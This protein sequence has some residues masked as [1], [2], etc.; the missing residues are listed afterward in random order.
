MKPWLNE[1]KIK[2]QWLWGNWEGLKGQQLK[3]KLLEKM[4]VSEDAQKRFWSFAKIKGADDC[5]DWIRALDS[6]GYGVF[7]CQYEPKKRTGI[8]AHRISYFLTHGLLPNHLCVC[9]RCDNTK[10][11]NPA[12]L[13]LGT[14]T[15][16]RRDSVEKDRHC[17]GERQGLHK[18]T[19]TQVTEIRFLHFYDRVNCA[20]ISQSFGVSRQCIHAITNG[21][22]WKHVPFPDEVFNDP[23]FQ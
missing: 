23:M 6:Y 2:T 3:Q 4:V 17:R 22:T 15:D 10:C 16:N 5:W 9:H 21:R 8:L 13:F 7:S 11:V 19:E 14:N 20:A 18:L 12:H 1:R